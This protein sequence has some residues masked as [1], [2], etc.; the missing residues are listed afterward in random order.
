MN[1][2]LAKA[3]MSCAVFLIAVAANASPSACERYMVCGSYKAETKDSNGHVSVKKIVVLNKSETQAVIQFVYHA[4]QNPDVLD[5]TLD[6][7]PDGS[8]TGTVNGRVG[9]S[10]FCGKS[11]CTFS[12]VPMENPNQGAY[13][14][15]GVLRFAPNTI[16]YNKFVAA[17]SG[18][19]RYQTVY[20]KE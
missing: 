12:L 6:F 13:G 4:E 18:Q 9:A 10:G 11:M 15:T 17:S 1:R 8:F 3:A 5:I 14:I 19:H 7:A 16:E 20:V 2:F